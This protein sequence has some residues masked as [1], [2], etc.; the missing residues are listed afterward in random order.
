MA[1]RLNPNDDLAVAGAISAPNGSSTL[2][3]QG[4]GNLVLYRA[5]GT[6]RWASNT[7]GKSVSQAI[8]QGDGN[9]VMYGPGGEYVWDTATDGHPGAY[10]IVQD[11]GNVVIYDPAGVPLWA[12]NTNVTRVMVPG[13]LPST[14][15]FHFSNSNFEHV[16]DITINIMGQQIRIG[17]AANGLCG[18]MVFAARDYFEA[19]IPIPSETTNPS[20]GTLF[21]YMVR[22]LFDSF[23]LYLPLP[24]LPPLPGIFFTPTPPF[25]PGPYT[26]MHLMNPALPD[27][28]TVASKVGFS[29]RGR[30]WVTIMDEWPKIKA[31]LDSGRLSPTALVEIK[32]LDPTQMGNNHQVLTYGY[33]LDGADLLMRLYDPNYPDDDTV[34]MS[35]NIAAPEQT[36]SISNSVVETVWCF[37]RPAYI[38]SFP[39]G[40]IQ[41]QADWRWCHQCQGLFF[42]GGQTA[43]GCCP[44]GGQHQ[45]GISGNYVLAHNS[46]VAHGQ[47][48]WR[49]CSKCQG[50]FFSGGQADAGNCPA[51]GQHQKGVSGN[52]RLLHDAPLAPGQSDWR[53]CHKCQGL[54]FSGGQAA[55]GSCPAGGQHEKGVS[56]KYT[57][58]HTPTP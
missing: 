24:P 51:G 17:D 7:E 16:P 9:F 40:G 13:F 34:T 52:Y 3:M 22:R 21:D 5:G 18:G 1:D 35:L 26:Y 47:A 2:V 56:G 27:H 57:L 46:P 36:T 29:Y 11:D 38:F 49:W 8:M 54:F 6:A 50:L 39:P 19:D 42:S 14:S 30:A 4:D 48:D 41:S 45:K 10:L 37:F 53:W 55:T 32:S 44:A 43:T 33:E 28:E 15:G 31:D 12:S 25:G 20:S 58:A 23:N